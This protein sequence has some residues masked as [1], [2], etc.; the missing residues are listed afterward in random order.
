MLFKKDLPS[1][2]GGIFDVLVKAIQ[3]HPTIKL[4]SHNRMADWTLWGCSIAEG[5]GY[6]KEEFLTAYTNNIVRQTEMLL[7]ENIVAIALFSFMEDED[8]WRGT[9]TE[10][11][12][13]L[14]TQ[15]SFVDIDTR[16]KY[17]PKAS[18]SL[19]RK[20]NELSTYLKQMGILVTI[21][22]SGS[23]REIYVRKT[24]PKKIEPITTQEE[25][26]DEISRSDDTD[27]ISG[28]LSHWRYSAEDPR[29]I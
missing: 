27:D 11:L 6:T 24:H 7:N 12:R 22:T 3:I 20:L 14:S 10:L 25:L 26:L 18:N 28:P 4:T 2:L 9:P 5:L 1:I 8:E 19:S 17:W 13:K 23:E 16:E 21:S 15:A 29:V